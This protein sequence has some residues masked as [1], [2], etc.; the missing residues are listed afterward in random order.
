[1][2]IWG[3]DPGISGALCYYDTKEQGIEVFDMPTV[4]VGKRK[5][6][7]AY[8]LVDILLNGE[9]SKTSSSTPNTYVI[10]ERVH[11]M[12]GQGV[13]SMFSFGQSFGIIQGVVAGLSM[14]IQTVTPHKWKRDLAV[15][16][17]KD[18]SRAM[19]ISQFPNSSQ[20]FSRKKDDGR[21]EASLLALWGYKFGLG[22]A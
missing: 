22:D 19:A 6:V 13:S 16:K 3:I 10:L 7:N 15:P 1:M 2:N 12:P 11:A 9:W 4:T 5:E 20:R 18:G 21:A 8:L 17:G 14:R